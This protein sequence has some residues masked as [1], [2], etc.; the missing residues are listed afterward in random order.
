MPIKGKLPSAPSMP[1]QEL[2]FINYETVKHYLWLFSTSW[3]ILN[4]SCQQ[5]MLTNHSH[6]FVT[7]TENL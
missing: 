4:F 3:Q 2:Q 6:V 5:D 1:T 7:Y